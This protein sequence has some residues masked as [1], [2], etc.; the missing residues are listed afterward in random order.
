MSV[1]LL[2]APVGSVIELRVTGPD[3]EQA[4]ASLKELVNDGFGEGKD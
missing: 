3:E 2:A 1:M 4:F